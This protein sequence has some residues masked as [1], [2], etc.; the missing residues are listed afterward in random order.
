MEVKISLKN[1]FFH[2]RANKS[3]VILFCESSA[4]SASE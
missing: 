2:Q 4:F 1:D 3:W